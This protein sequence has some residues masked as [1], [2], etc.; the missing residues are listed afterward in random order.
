MWVLYWQDY[1]CPGYVTVTGGSLWV[2]WSPSFSS[3]LSSSCRATA[4]SLGLF[5]R[6]NFSLK[7]LGPSSHV[8]FTSGGVGHWWPLSQS[9]GSLP[10][11]F[12]SPEQKAQ[13]HFHTKKP[14]PSQVSWTPNPALGS[15]CFTRT[16][17]MKQPHHS[18]VTKDTCK[19]KIIVQFL[20]S[21][22]R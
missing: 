1:R 14:D 12:V 13:P 3:C 4:A 20:C 6:G 21:F 22:P 5:P 16:A 7:Y 19:K 15:L 8:T 10:A 2:F 11:S 18:T 9:L 17:Q